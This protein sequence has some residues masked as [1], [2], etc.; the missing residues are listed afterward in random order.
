MRDYSY[1]REKRLLPVYRPSL[2]IMPARRL[3]LVWLAWSAWVGF[4]AFLV[5]R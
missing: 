5:V 1:P 2:Q 4:L 3:P